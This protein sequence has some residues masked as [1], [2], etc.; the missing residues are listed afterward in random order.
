MGSD[1]SYKIVKKDYEIPKEEDFENEKEYD[2]HLEGF[3]YLYYC[4]NSWEGPK[5]F[6]NMY[7]RHFMILRSS[8]MLDVF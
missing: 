7:S 8:S 2:K 5:G 4:R 3:E 6:G 1:L